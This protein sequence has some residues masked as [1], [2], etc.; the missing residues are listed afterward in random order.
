MNK[1]LIAAILCIL[2][3]LL[4]VISTALQPT[5]ESPDKQKYN[6]LMKTQAG[7]F[8]QEETERK[9]RQEMMQTIRKQNKGGNS[10]GNKTAPFN[11]DGSTKEQG[12]MEGDWATKRKDGESGLQGLGSDSH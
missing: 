1:I 8:K 2:V 6:D 5:K 10:K 7:R 9:Q 4:A 11:N 12:Y 3:G